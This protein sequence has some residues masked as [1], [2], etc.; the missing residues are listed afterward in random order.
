LYN[1]LDNIGHRVV[2]TTA[3]LTHYR[4]NFH[5]LVRDKL[6]NVGIEYKLIY[7]QP[8]PAD[9]EK[10][11][12]AEIP[13]ATKIRNYY[14]V[15]IASAATW[16]PFFGELH[17]KDF[18]VLGQQNRLLANYVLQS[19]R[20]LLSIRIAL[21][22]HGRNF[23][24]TRPNELAELWKRFWARQ[25]DWWFTYTEQTGELIAGYG[26]SREKITVLDNAIDTSELRQLSTSIKAEDLARL[27]RDL[28]IDTQNLGVYVGGIYREK[29]IDFLIDACT[30][31]RQEIPDFVL[32]V[33]GSGADRPLV[34]AAAAQY[35]WIRYL[36]PKFG[37]EKV[38]ILKLS[39][40]FLMPGLVGL[41]V[42]DC[43]AL[44]LPMITTAYPYHSPEIAY[45]RD[46]HNGIMVQ[47]WE[48]SSAYAKAVVNTLRD[49][50]LYKKLV[51]GALETGLR[52]T[53][54]NMAERFV[55]GVIKAMQI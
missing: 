55:N 40:V 11:D 36:G 23:Q 25:C 29:R 43:F 7:G 50:A 48:N 44:G 15:S 8:G 54:E 31:V 20:R 51:A 21:W 24:S 49:S 32:V 2:F 52:Y 17:S 6:S 37:R 14:G 34:E 12:C 26:F 9:A 42:L 18:V 13:W 5:E 30:A 28:G 22:G 1:S 45:L 35:P 41:A 4:V 33:V 10:G 38:E 19:S 39:R 16:Q 53:T 47:E 3:T 27:R 46:S